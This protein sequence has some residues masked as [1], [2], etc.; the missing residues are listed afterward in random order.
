[1]SIADYNEQFAGL[2]DMLYETRDVRKEARFAAELLDLDNGRV[3]EPHIL[4]FGCGTGSHAIAF[5]QAGIAV[6]GFDPS[7][8]MIDHARAKQPAAE[9]APIRFA[10]GTFAGFCERLNGTRFDG[11]VSFFNVLN[12]MVSPE[13]MRSHLLL[14][15]GRL[16]VGAKFLID[17]WN[18]AAVLVDGPRP[19]VRGYAD[20]NSPDREILRITVPDVDRINQV[21]TLRYRVLTLD[22]AAGRFTEFESVHTLRFL[23]PVQYRDLFDLA[24]LTLVDEFP[25]TCPGTPITEHDWYISYLLRRD[26]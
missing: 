17:V 3:D 7:D 8:A 16:A 2:Y 21:C 1:M 20:E 23:T 11:S 18:G 9:S 10:T 25:K 26:S 4:D 13:A 12:C 6:T 5:A 24:G 14:L 22:R 19:G 15:R